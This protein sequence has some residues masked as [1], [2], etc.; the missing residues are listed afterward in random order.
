MG[1]PRPT[2]FTRL[3]DE[4]L[5]ALADDNADNATEKDWT[6]KSKSTQYFVVHIHALDDIYEDDIW[7]PLEDNF[8]ESMFKKE[9]IARFCQAYEFDVSDVEILSFKIVDEEP[10]G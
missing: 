9:A 7:W 2:T 1:M 8:S 3:H 6:P 10:E 5:Q 4:V